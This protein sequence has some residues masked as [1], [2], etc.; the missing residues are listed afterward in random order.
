MLP[1]V[2]VLVLGSG[3]IV[4]LLYQRGAFSAADTA[5]VS[6]VQIMYAWQLSFG[7]VAILYARLLIAMKRN[8]LIMVSAAL[9]LGLDIVLNLVCMRYLGVAGI[10][11]ATSL[12]YFGSF[13]FFQTMGRYLLGRQMKLQS[14]LAMGTLCA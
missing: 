11:L 3:T 13:L 5:L 1:L 10:A 4:R 6:R 2:A 8:D 7:G 9:N 12:F 14:S